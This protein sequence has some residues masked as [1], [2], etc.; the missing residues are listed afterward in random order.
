MKGKRII[1]PKHFK[2]P[3]TPEPDE[4]EL[5]QEIKELSV[6]EKNLSGNDWDNAA[7]NVLNH[8]RSV[9]PSIAIVGRPNVGKSS[10]FN[11]ILKRRQ[12][13]VHFDSGVTRDRVS[14]SGVYNNCRF[15]LIDTGG[16]G[17]YNGEKKGVGFWDQMIA[18]QVI[19]EIRSRLNFLVNVGLDPDLFT[20]IYLLP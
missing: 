4:T 9:L 2:R 8:V 5:N 18:Q 10:L 13:I 1:K 12:A 15:N 11:A 16:L 3:V 7:E 14:A 19:K 6:L 17:M 20:L